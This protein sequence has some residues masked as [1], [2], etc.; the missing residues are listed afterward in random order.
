MDIGIITDSTAY[1]ETSFVSQY[2]I[3]IAPL[4]IHFQDQNYQ[5]GMDISAEEFYE[6]MQAA[7]H[8]P[9]SSQPSYGLILELL[10][11]ALDSYDQLLVVTLSKEIS[12]TY[13]SFV[14]AAKEID[15]DNIYIFDSGS[16]CAPQANFVQEAVF[17]RDHGKSLEDIVQDLEKV[18]ASTEV[19][20]SVSDLKNF[21]KSGRVSNASVLLGD[22]LKIRPILRFVEGK[23]VVEDKVR[24]SR[25]VINRFMDCFDLAYQSPKKLKVYVL[26]AKGGQGSEARQLIERMQARYPEV[27]VH[28][29]TVGPV[30]GIHTG[31]T[32]FSMTW[33]EKV[34]L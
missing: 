20:L 4:N 28:T 13:D 1:L 3:K 29:A 19:F 34:D 31:P 2:D 6:K 12:G 15:P 7:E 14:M 32:V 17:L 22:F 33:M 5:D 16:S 18:K 9:Q 8:L 23:I 27:P 21:A 10:E 30:I 24:S 11:K 25:R 26:D